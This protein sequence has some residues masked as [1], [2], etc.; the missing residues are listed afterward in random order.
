[1]LKYTSWVIEC[2]T[3][4]GRPY[5]KIRFKDLTILK[6]TERFDCR[7]DAEEALKLYESLGNRGRLRKITVTRREA[8]KLEGTM[9]WQKYLLIKHLIA[10]ALAA[11]C[12]N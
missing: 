2:L 4:Q 6:R 9:K 8:L 12:V 10:L 1:M 11:S 5:R 7:D 3:E